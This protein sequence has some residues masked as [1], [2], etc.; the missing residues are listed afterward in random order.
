MLGLT[1]AA[2]NQTSKQANVKTF[3]DAVT[4]SLLTGTVPVTNSLLTGTVPVNYSVFIVKQKMNDMKL[5]DMKP[6]VLN[7]QRW[8]QAPV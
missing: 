2:A 5:N 4:N 8:L 1:Q 3:D 6:I 7:S